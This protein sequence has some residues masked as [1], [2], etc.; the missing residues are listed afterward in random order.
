VLTLGKNPLDEVLV[1]EMPP[2]FDHTKKEPPSNQLSNL[3]NFLGSC[4]KLL[5]DK[6]YLQVLQSLS[7]KC[8]SRE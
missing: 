1:Y 5:N 6:N 4:V 8:N 3:R 2:L 7:E